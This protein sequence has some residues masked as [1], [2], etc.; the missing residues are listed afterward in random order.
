MNT[1]TV[2]GTVLAYTN[3]FACIAGAGAGVSMA[4]YTLLFHRPVRRVVIGVVLL[5]VCAAYAALIDNTGLVHTNGNSVFRIAVFVGVLCGLG[6]V[7]TCAGT[8]NESV[9]HA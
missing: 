8:R 1:L 7:S 9:S 5:N 3:A 6:I 4:V 2:F